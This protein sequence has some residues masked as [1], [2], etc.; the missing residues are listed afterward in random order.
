MP[1]LVLLVILVLLAGCREG[2]QVLSLDEIL[3]SDVGVPVYYLDP[4]SDYTDL[5][6][7]YYYPDDMSEMLVATYFLAANSGSQTV[8]VAV[9]F[10]CRYCGGLID[11]SETRGQAPASVTWA[12][13]DTGACRAEP[14]TY[15]ENLYAGDPFQSCLY[16]FDQ[17]GNVYKLYSVWSEEESVDFANLLVL[18]ER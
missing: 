13:G 6:V 3:N 18:A 11:A 1:I 5:E 7:V 2:P 14:P 10:T 9:M 17:D 4:G 8:R 12:R 15:R 16:W